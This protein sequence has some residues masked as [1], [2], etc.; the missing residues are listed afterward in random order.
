MLRFAEKQE[1]AGAGWIKPGIYLFLRSRLAAIEAG[2][3]SSLERDVLPG[4][5]ATGLRAHR[6]YGRFIDIGTPGSYAEASAFFG[7]GR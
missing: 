1:G 6:T 2:R 5:I 7:G 3:A 4:W